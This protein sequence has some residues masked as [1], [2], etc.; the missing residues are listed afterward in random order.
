MIKEIIIISV[1]VIS[2]LV[3]NFAYQSYITKSSDSLVDKLGT[4]GEKIKADTDNIKDNKEISNL[5]NNVENEW[6]NS[7]KIWSIF[8]MHNELDQIEIAFTNIKTS[9]DIDYRQYAAVET[10]KAKFLLEHIAER[11]SFKLKNLF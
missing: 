1:V 10:E 4:L 9:I 8:V 6:E 5:L 11:D 3:C 7:K 2:I